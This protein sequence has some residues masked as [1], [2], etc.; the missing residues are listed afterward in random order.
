MKTCLLKSGEPCPFNRVC[1]EP[2]RSLQS[3]L[4]LTGTAC[5]AYDFIASKRP[6]LLRVVAPQEKDVA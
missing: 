2:R 5:W 6:D 3:E 4:G 1:P